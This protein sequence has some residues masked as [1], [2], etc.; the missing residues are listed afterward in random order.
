MEEATELFGLMQEMLQTAAMGRAAPLAAPPAQERPPAPP[1]PTGPGN[2]DWILLGLLALGAGTGLLTAAA[3]RLAT[4][5]STDLPK[6]SPGS[7]S[8]S[9]GPR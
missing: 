1:R 7:S 3:K 6:S 2:D 8:A 5:T 9:P 4:A